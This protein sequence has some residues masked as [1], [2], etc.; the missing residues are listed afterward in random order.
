MRTE[1]DQKTWKQLESNIWPK[2]KIQLP[3]D[4]LLSLLLIF[5]YG[6]IVLLQ[7]WKWESNGMEMSAQIT[8]ESD[9]SKHNL[10]R[11][12]INHWMAYKVSIEITNNKILG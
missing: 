12:P 6:I 9:S 1:L 4:S 7:N 10:N 2:L 5:N 8:V 11:F 3:V